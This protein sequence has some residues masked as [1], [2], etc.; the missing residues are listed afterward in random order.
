[1]ESKAI[2]SVIIPNFN[3]ADLLPRCLD[4]ILNQTFS[5]L[6]IIV[7]DDGSTDESEKVLTK[8]QNKDKR[9]KVIYNKHAGLS[10]SRNT[11]I[12]IAQ[13]EYIGFIDSDDAIEKDFYEKLYN[14][15]IKTD[16]DVVMTSTKLFINN[17]YTGILQPYLTFSAKNL[18]EKISIL[19]GGGVWDKIYKRSFLLKHDILFPVGKNYEG[20]LFLLKTVY[21]ANQLYFCPDSFYIY[22]VR[23]G[24]IC[25]TKTEEHV[26]KNLEDRCFILEEMC[27]FAKEHK[28]SK[29][30]LL[31]M[32]KY[33]LFSVADKEDI[34]IKRFN[35]ILKNI[36]IKNLIKIKGRK[37]VIKNC[38]RF[39]LKY[40][41][42]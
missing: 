41:R 30:A 6:E 5:Q 10:A 19:R 3:N 9:I 25:T 42:S 40:K 11:G 7:V 17:N 27:K 39:Y 15:A 37:W 14:N 36:G 24:S 35:I 22:Y 18:I 34:Y 28:F 13:G 16:A 31:A 23:D 8:Y 12:H 4:S 21:F 32:H 26:R 38:L 2:I 29:H 33:I 20:N 1:M